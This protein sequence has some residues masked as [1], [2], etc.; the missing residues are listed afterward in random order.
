MSTKY[1][2]IG[3]LVAGILALSSAYGDT[4]LLTNPGFEDGTAGWQAFGGCKLTTS[5]L[6][7]RS[8][9]S[10]GYASNRTQNYQG[11]AQPLLGKLQPDKTYRITAW[12][13]LEG[14]SAGNDT[15]KATIKKVDD[16]GAS[17]DNVS[18]STGSNNQW[19][20]LSGQYTLTV[21]GTLTGLDIYFEGPAADV[22]FYVD[23]VNVLG[24]PP[25]PA[26]PAAPAEPNTGK[27]NP[28]PRSQQIKDFGTAGTCDACQPTI[29]SR[30]NEVYSLLS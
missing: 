1:F 3:L 27:D 22:N 7:Y 12:I 6:Q 2:C 13:K 24:P 18:T 20:Q 10:S 15:I 14:A 23:D 16:S 26:A 11:I 17:Y 30:K 9:T 5:T 29:H 8:G 25:A 19:S 4:N 21:N 28:T